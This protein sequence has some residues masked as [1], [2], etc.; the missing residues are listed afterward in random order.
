MGEIVSGCCVVPGVAALVAAGFSV[1]VPVGTGVSVAV[2]SWV[3][4]SNAGGTAT[5]PGAGVAVGLGAVGVEVGAGVSGTSVGP[6][7]AVRTAT[8]TRNGV[9]RSF[10][11]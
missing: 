10:V 5:L 11:I 2:G 3:F 6:E 7:H 8:M 9:S 4:G 1:G